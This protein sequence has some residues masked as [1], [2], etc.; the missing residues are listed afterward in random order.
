MA[1]LASAAGEATLVGYRLQNA[2][3]ARFCGGRGVR[4]TIPSDPLASLLTRLE[5]NGVVVDYFLFA[6]DD[7]TSPVDAAHRSAATSGMSV[8]EARQIT[9]NEERRRRFNH[10]RGLDPSD[11]SFYSQRPCYRVV[12]DITKATAAEEHPESFL[13]DYWRAFSDA[14]HGPSIAQPELAELFDE[15]NRLLFGNLSDWSIR[16]WST[17]WSNYFEAGLEWWGAYFWTLVS[18]DRRRAVVVGASS[19]D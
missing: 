3:M 15:V 5:Q 10:W 16:R 8:I 13:K 9:I 7:A 11:S 14:P 18:S 4:E 17:D 12:F 19:T 6:P 1:S 2:S